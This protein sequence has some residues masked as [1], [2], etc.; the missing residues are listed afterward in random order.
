M[1]RQDPYRCILPERDSADLRGTAQRA[2]PKLLENPSGKTTARQERRKIRGQPGQSFKGITVREPGTRTLTVSLVSD[3][4][5]KKARFGLANY[6]GPH[7]FPDALHYYRPKE[8]S[9]GT[10][11]GI[12]HESNNRSGQNEIQ[13]FPL[14]ESDCLED[15]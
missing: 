2:K 15:D 5:L 6:R 13:S 4:T 12:S 9:D 11:Y 8:C 14:E 3:R 10:D 1:G 7:T